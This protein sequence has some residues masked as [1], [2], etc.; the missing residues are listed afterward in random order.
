MAGGIFPNYPFHF[1]IKCIIF[2]L[3]I[4]LGYWYLP[5]KNIIVFIFLLWLPYIALAWYDYSYKCDFKMMPTILPFARYIF[6]PFKPPGYKAEFNKLPKN[7]ITAMDTLDHITAFTLLIILGAVI[8]S[9]FYNRNNNK[10]KNKKQLI[11]E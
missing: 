2:T 4:A 1:N 3:V 11:N 5:T 8:F 7:A 9:Y 10:N 6:L